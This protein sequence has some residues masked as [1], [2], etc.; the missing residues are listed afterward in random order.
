MRTH[1][2]ILMLFALLPLAGWA[3]GILAPNSYFKNGNFVYQVITTPEA[4]GAAG[5]ARLVGVREGY[6]P[7]DADNKLNLDGHFTIV[8]LEDNYTLDVIEATA[9]ALKNNYDIVAGVLTAKG[10]FAGKT[11][12]KTVVIPK[13]YTTIKAGTFEGYTNLAS[14][15]FEADAEVTTIE[16][17][18]FTTTQISNFDFTNCAKLTTIQAG[19]FVETIG[20]T[21]Q[22]N[23]YITTISLPIGSSVLTTIGTAFQNLPNLTALNHLD[24]TKITTIEAKAFENDAKLK[25]L[26]LPSTVQTIAEG[27]FEGSGVEDLTI[28]VTSL[29]DVTACATG[30]VYSTV[31]YSAT[32][33][34]YKTL[35]KLTLKGVLAGEF[36]SKAFKNCTSLATLDM[37]NLTINGGKIG[38]NAFDGC[39][40]LTALTFNDITEGTIGAQAFNGCTALTSVVFGKITGTEIADALIDDSAFEGCTKLADIT[41]GDLTHV[42]I[43]ANAFK[44]CASAA[45]LASTATKTL[46]F[47]ALTDVDINASAFEGCAKLATI[48]FGAA[49]NLQIK[50]NAFK[51]CATNANAT[52]TFS[53]LKDVAIAGTVTG[54]GAFYNCTKLGVIEF[55]TSENLTIGNFAFEE[56][57]KNFAVSSTAKSTLTF[58]NAKNIVIGGNAFYSVTAT[59][60][61]EITFGDIEDDAAPT[62]EIAAN[63]FENATNLKTLTFGNLTDVKISGDAFKAA[64]S[65]LTGN[66]FAEATFGDL[67]GSEIEDK[68]FDGA[69]RL[70]IVTIGDV[71]LG[72]VIG[73]TT[74]PSGVFPA[75]KKATIGTISGGDDVIGGKAFTFG[76]YSNAEMNLASA[77]GKYLQHVSGTAQLVAADAIDFVATTGTGISSFIKPVVNIGEIKTP[78]ALAA[79]ALKGNNIKKITFTGNIVANGLNKMIIADNSDATSALTLNELVFDGAIAAA[80]I[81]ADAF[82]GLPVNPTS[83][84]FNGKLAA[85]AV[86]AAAFADLKGDTPVA[87]TTTTHSIVTYTYNEN[88][89]DVTVNPFDKRA[90]VATSVT[91]SDQDGDSDVDIDDIDI[92]TP[93]QIQLSIKNTDLA[94]KFYE[95]TPSAGLG[96]DGA[97]DIYRVIVVMPAAPTVPDWS[98]IAYQ[99][100][101]N[102]QN[103]AWARW[104]FGAKALNETVAP[105]KEITI[106]RVQNK[107]TKSD[108]TEVTGTIRVTLYGTYTDEDDFNQKTSIYMVPLKAIDGEYVIPGTNYETLIA[109]V[110]LKEGNFTTAEN[111]GIVKVAVSNTTTTLNSIWGGLQNTELFCASNIMTNQQLID[112]T[113][114]DAATNIAAMKGVAGGDNAGDY[115]AEATALGAS[116]IFHDVR[117]CTTVDGVNIYRSTTVGSDDTK[118]VEDLYRMRDPKAKMGFDIV[119]NAIQKGGAYIGTG[120][121]YMLLKK[122]ANDPAY[123]RVIWMDDDQATGI[124]G[125]KSDVN[126]IAT[127]NNAVYTLQGIRVNQ[128]QKGQLYIMNG[129]KFIAK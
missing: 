35:K 113:A 95:T 48:N 123:A 122:Y 38:D 90:F 106:Q 86:A 3:Q 64:S 51:S 121:Y 12:A 54:T 46:S 11:S 129:K 97:F 78:D 88:D 31:A 26:A 67:K 34:D 91:Y 57:S 87:G 75:L 89:I 15:S 126:N 101:A 104:E 83:I 18:A 125:V 68:A 128:L 73:T 118:V 70:A 100:Q 9:T 92:Q 14:I 107:Y 108:G 103:V 8:V 45:T 33:N 58:A 27:A 94:A 13:Q 96:T 7:V 99:D 60:F 115:L 6:N 36:K 29:N 120:V 44:S 114:V 127:V 23:S 105:G 77:T 24:Q 102:Q 124:F 62:V 17:G 56:C 42:T 4:N 85:G 5:T 79:K 50:T 81:A 116:G 63:A 39:T 16:S 112:K 43:D 93:R 82:A 72:S 66:D 119:K 117:N 111:D 47:G 37:T 74:T 84:T 52:L 59:K 55:G 20:G 61:S 28:D 76:N 80:G 25:T 40:A 49:D 21:K 65:A 19:L 98:M 10:E 53:T 71:T 32:V 110:E 41:F 30:N 1:F 109:K 22:T 2:L 69:S